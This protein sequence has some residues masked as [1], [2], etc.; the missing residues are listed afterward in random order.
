MRI[1]TFLHS[2]E[3]GGVERVALRLVRAWRRAGIDAPLVLGRSDGAM[4]H[5]AD[6]LAF[7]TLG[8]GRIPTAHWETLWMILRLPAVIRRLQ[9][10]VLFCAGN[11]YTVVSVA[12]KLWLGKRCPLIVAKVSNDLVRADMPGPVRALYHRWL[13]IQGR[14]IDHFTGMAAPM[15]A[16]I[17]AAMAIA[18]VRVSIIDDPALMMADVE[19]LHKCG[20]APRSGTHFIGV[21]RLAGQKNWPL[22]I[23]AFARIARADDRLSIVGEGNARGAIEREI[24]RHGIGA[25]V[26]LPGH[27]SDLAAWWRDASVFALSSDYEGVPAVVAE[28]LAVGIP[29]VATDCS[30]SMADM[31]GGGQLGTLV[32]VRD[33]S[34]LATALDAARA[35]IPDRDAMRRQAQR[36]TV[37]RAAR[38]YLDS[39]ASLLRA[40]TTLTHSVDDRQ[41]V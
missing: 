14:F 15:R 30:V 29:I 16:E 22:L 26:T 1:L 17:E 38:H 10:D 24:A 40:P 32:R 9:P 18:A 21:G 27:M 2:F 12:M 37:E 5:E 34:A 28:A 6:G 36:F 20:E 31:L 4:R 33:E 3:P 19:R 41:P 35:A 23:R 8:T 39:F 11:S 7:E 25:R 13:R